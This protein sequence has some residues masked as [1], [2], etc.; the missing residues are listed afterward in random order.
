MGRRWEGG[1]EGGN[2]CIL[3]ADSCRGLTENRKILQSNYPSIK[4]NLK[5]EYGSRLPLPPPGDLPNPGIKPTSLYVCIYTHT[6][7]HIS[8]IQYYIC[9]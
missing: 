5:K 7:T 3:M 1:S 8:C 9:M 2:L 4:N 6:H